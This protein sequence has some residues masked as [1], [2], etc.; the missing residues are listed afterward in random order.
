[1][2][3][4]EEIYETV[5]N[6]KRG[7]VEDLVQKALDEG[8]SPMAMIEE[9]LR[10]AMNEVGE[11]F[12]RAEFFLPDLILAAD[13]MKRATDYLRPLLADQSEFAAQETVVIGTVEGDLHD[14]G[15]NLVISTLEGA[16]YRVVDLGVDAAINKFVEAAREYDPAVIGFSAL[17]AAREY[18]PAVIG[19][20]ALLST[21][22][23]NI[24]KTIRALEDADLR[25]GRIL[26]VGG[27]PITQRNANEWGVEIYAPDAGT[28]VRVINDA[29]AH[30]LQ[31]AQEE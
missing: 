17:L 5:L 10:P 25:Q 8:V 7:E 13:A 1:V 27:A 18:D 31:S 11:R 16:G 19:F 4:L 6:G 14:I 23:V 2:S 20:S 3:V 21:T 24:P 9:T 12:S 28:A 15:K 30:R 29:L 26:A 22:M